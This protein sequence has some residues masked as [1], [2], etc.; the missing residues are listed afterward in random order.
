MSLGKRRRE[1]ENLLNLKK[2]RQMEGNMNKENESIKQHKFY[3]AMSQNRYG[4]TDP[5]PFII[6]VFDKD[7]NKKL[8][9]YHDMSIAREFTKVK[10]CIAE[11]KIIDTQKVLIFCNTAAQA[12]SM[13]EH[14]V[15][16]VNKDWVAIVPDSRIT[17]MGIVGN[18]PE[19][20]GNKEVL[21]AIKVSDSFSPVFKVERLMKRNPDVDIS[22]DG[23]VDLLP[24]PMIK[25]FCKGLSLPN[26]IK[27]FNVERTVRLFYP[28]IKRCAKCLRF[29]HLHNTCKGKLRCANCT[30]EHCVEDCASGGIICV[31]CRSTD[32]NSLSMLC[33]CF[34]QEQNINKIKHENRL[35]YQEAKLKY[36]NDIREGETNGKDLI[37]SQVFYSQNT[38]VANTSQSV[39]SNDSG[40]TVT[41]VESMIRIPQGHV[42]VDIKSSYQS[43]VKKFTKI[44]KDKVGENEDM[45]K[46]I[47]E[48]EALYLEGKK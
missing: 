26:S 46:L 19:S 17:T 42:L 15:M 13:V 22:E 14:K 20:Y 2:A 8:G 18:I 40:K 7:P 32:H 10:D 43:E 48:T 5:G 33:P 39:S 28:K 29:G 1:S 44:L 36:L 6:Y 37:Y 34:L 16:E 38:N 30:G 11:I 45:I 23:E 25:I 21:E 47:N 31:H 3:M 27:L 12:N 35:S 24:T 9:N 4:E 41:T